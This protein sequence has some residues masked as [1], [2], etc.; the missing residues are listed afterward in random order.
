M[1]DLQCSCN[2]NGV[3]I[4]IITET[5]KEEDMPDEPFNLTGYWPPAN[6]DRVGFK[7]GGV[8]IYVKSTMQM[9]KLENLEEEHIGSL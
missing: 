7:G 1:Y 9:V 5:W 4:A 2:L 3:D 6:K 8:A